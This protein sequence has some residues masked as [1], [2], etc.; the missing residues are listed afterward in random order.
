[1]KKIVGAIPVV[2]ELQ[3][4]KKLVRLVPTFTLISAL[5]V[6]YWRIDM[7]M[8]SKMTTMVE[9]GVYAAAYRLMEACKSLPLSITRAMFP[10]LSQ[11]CSADLSR[12]R[13][14]TNQVYKWTALLIIP[15][16]AGTAIVADEIV[17]FFYKAKFMA[18][19]PVLQIL[20]WTIVPYGLAMILANVLVACNLQKYDL[21]V[22]LIACSL[23]L[24]LNFVL[25]KEHSYLGASYATVIS[26]VVFFA[27]QL[28]FV[29]RFLFRLN[30]VALL[31]R[32]LVASL[33]MAG[34]LFYSADL[35][36]LVRAVTAGG[37]YILALGLM[38]TFTREE[39]ASLGLAKFD[40]PVKLLMKKEKVTMRIVE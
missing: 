16:A 14:K 10:G 21:Y 2:V 33:V 9:V 25:I 40:W 23:N 30:Y 6:L 15:L 38:R 11:M 35:P 20:I 32:P 22:N 13:A 12:A 4:V 5:S 37:V 19:V 24:G 17:F 39:W 26:I 18:A 7:L 36:L 29:R 31:V 8:L 34:F 27:L 28:Y 1:V 3:F